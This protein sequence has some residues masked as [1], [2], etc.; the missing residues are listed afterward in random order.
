MARAHLVLKNAV[1]LRVLVAVGDAGTQR[2]ARGKAIEEAALDFHGVTF[3]AGC[4]QCALAGGAARHFGGDSLLVQ[5]KA[6][7]QSV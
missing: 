3:L 1:I 4:G 7:R 6:R 5:G 2:C